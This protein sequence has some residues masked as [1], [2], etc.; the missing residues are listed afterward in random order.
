MHFTKYLL[1]VLLPVSPISPTTNDARPLKCEGLEAAIPSLQQLPM[2]ESRKDGEDG[3]RFRIA[4]TA[5]YLTL[6]YTSNN[7]TTRD[8]IK[9]DESDILQLK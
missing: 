2:S 9:N 4:I 6:A 3:K 5:R 7:G 8:P 1:I